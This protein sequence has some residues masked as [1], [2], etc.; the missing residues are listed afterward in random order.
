MNLL[1]RCN[2]TGYEVGSIFHELAK[3]LDLTQLQYEDYWNQRDNL[4]DT[5]IQ[6]ISTRRAVV[7]S[8]NDEQQQL[9]QECSL[10]PKTTYQDVLQRN[11]DLQDHNFDPIPLVRS[12][13]SPK[14][15][16]ITSHVSASS[17]STHSFIDEQYAM[18]DSNVAWYYVFDLTASKYWF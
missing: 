15:N 13:T 2:L 17:T 5:P 3:L 9:R 14:V 18:V 10:P 16:I 8:N 12:I 7:A 1:N 6:I 11:H 4:H